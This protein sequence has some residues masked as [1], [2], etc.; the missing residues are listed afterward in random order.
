MGPVSECG[1]G[2]RDR[3]REREEG[4][5]WNK[6]MLCLMSVDEERKRENGGNRR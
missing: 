1:R 3:Q 4:Q 5:G 2:L 6:I